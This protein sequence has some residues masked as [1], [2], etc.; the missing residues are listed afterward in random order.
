M[1]DSF[2][3]KYDHWKDELDDDPDP[4]LVKDFCIKFAL[5]VMKVDIEDMVETLDL[6]QIAIDATNYHL[7][8]FLDGV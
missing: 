1:Q 7:A 3:V 4:S 6:K 5:L 2:S 8:C